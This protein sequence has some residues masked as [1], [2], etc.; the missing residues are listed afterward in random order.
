MHDEFNRNF[1]D[2]FLY[3]H[4]EKMRRSKGWSGLL[5]AGLGFLGGSL[6][7]GGGGGGGRV[8]GATA[9]SVE[10]LP[11]LSSEQQGILNQLIGL[12]GPQIG[13]VGRV[14]PSGLGPIGPSALQQQAF[15]VAGGLPQYLQSPAFGQFDPSQITQAMEPVG[16]FARQGFQQETIPAIM[17]GLG[18]QGAARSSGAANI[19]AREGRNLELGL[20][21]Q[22][23]PMQFQAQQAQLGRQAMLPGLAG[24]MGGQMANIGALQRGIPGEQQAFELSRY[25]AQ[26]PFRNPAIALALQSAGIPT[27][28]NVVFGGQQG[29]RQPSMLESLLPM[30]GQ[31]AGGAMAGGYF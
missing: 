29:Y 10:Q 28:E 9:P 3:K 11:T 30:V 24:Q 17:G 13:Q 18:F 1:T 14:P 19:L 15:G 8:T 12:A 7:G 27:Q 2:E 25:M 5:G 22:F 21:S 23:G 6:F 16:Q 20:A 31:I 4:S 26:D